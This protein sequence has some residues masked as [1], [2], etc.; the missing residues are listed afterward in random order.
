METKENIPFSECMAKRITITPLTYIVIAV[1]LTMFVAYGMLDDKQ[2]DTASL[3]FMLGAAFTVFTT[4]MVVVKGRQFYYKPTGSGITRFTLY[5]DANTEAQIE[6]SVRTGN[7]AGLSELKT[8]NTGQMVV[9]LYLSKDNA[10]G[11][12]RYKKYQGYTYQAQ[13]EWKRLDETQ[14]QQLT[15]YINA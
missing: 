8:S 14:C 15:H 6:D 11:A 3:L 10:F 4:Y 7:M 9:E 5:F 1:T 2:S 13:C 12:I